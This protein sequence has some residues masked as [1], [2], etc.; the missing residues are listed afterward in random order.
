MALKSRL[1]QG[2]LKA[3]PAIGEL[4]EC[5]SRA[6]ACL[7]SKALSGLLAAALLRWQLMIASHAFLQLQKEDEEDLYFTSGGQQTKYLLDGLV[8]PLACLSVD[9]SK[10]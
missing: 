3:K 8:G 9:K 5:H 1:S 7:Q 10:S 6:A 4:S 2:H